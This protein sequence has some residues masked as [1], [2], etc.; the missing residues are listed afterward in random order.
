M[1]EAGTVEV[2][3]RLMVQVRRKA[4]FGCWVKRLPSRDV[5]GSKSRHITCYFLAS[6]S[7][8]SIYAELCANTAPYQ[9][10]NSSLTL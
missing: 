5:V 7:L 1:N 4:G 8:F 2:G 10:N 9:Y 3:N 6:K